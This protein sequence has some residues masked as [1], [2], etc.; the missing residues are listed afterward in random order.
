MKYF[1]LPTYWAFQCEILETFSNVK[2]RILSVMSGYVSRTISL[3]VWNSEV[4]MVI[5][6]LTVFSGHSHL[7]S[8]EESGI[9]EEYMSS[10]R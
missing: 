3:G 10:T 6:G 4:L 8:S 1:S 7:N 5:K 2:C 9:C